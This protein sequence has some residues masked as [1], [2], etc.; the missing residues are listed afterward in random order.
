MSTEQEFGFLQG[1]VEGLKEDVETLTEA[2]KAHMKEEEEERKAMNKKIIALFVATIGL[3]VP[4][5]PWDFLFK[6]AMAML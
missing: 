3:Y 6:A 4:E 2:L 5:L 1:T